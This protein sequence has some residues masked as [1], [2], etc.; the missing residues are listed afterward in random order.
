MTKKA[1]VFITIGACILIG[2]RLDSFAAT[3]PAGTTL[4]VRTLETISGRAE[5][6]RKFNAELAQD[7]VVNN[8]VVLR[9][10]TKV[11]GK[12]DASRAMEMTSRPLTLNL[13]TISSNGHEVPVVTVQGFQAENTMRNSPKARR[14]VVTGN[15]FVFPMGAQMQFR[16]AKPVN[17]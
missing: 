9:A 13:A 1:F 4:V 12:V 10:G 7:V 5:V 2:S 6:G 8:S 11:I 16:L 14:V 3:I 17:L 15:E